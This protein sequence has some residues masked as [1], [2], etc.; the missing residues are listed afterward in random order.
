V[1]STLSVFEKSPISVGAFLLADISH[2]SGLIAKGLLNDP[3][4]HCHVVTTTT[5]KTLRGPRGGL[6]LMGKDFENP[7]GITLKSGKKRMMSSLVDGGVF[8]GNQGGPLEHVVAAK[9]GCLLEKPLLMSLCT[10]SFGCATM[11]KPWQKH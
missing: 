9:A 8:P 3:I 7:F 5:H 11:H 2:P 4:P 10:I 1:I 6:I